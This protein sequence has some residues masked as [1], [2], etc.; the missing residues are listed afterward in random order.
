M[1]HCPFCH[2]DR[3]PVFSSD[4]S[5]AIYD[6]YPVSEGHMLVISR[7]HAA[8]YFQ[9]DGEEKEDLWNLVERVREYLEEEYRPDG[10]NIGFN[11]NVA[12]GQTIF[13]L[14]IHVIPRYEGDVD[15]PTGGIRNVIPGKG[16]YV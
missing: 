8:S 16:K 13:H 4:Q 7:R 14:H 6:R 5:F 1:E 9:L 15:D 3:D 11:E 12:A 10:F 2:P